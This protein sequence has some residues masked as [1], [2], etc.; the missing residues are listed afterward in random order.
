MRFIK[1]LLVA[2]LAT[3]TLGGQVATAEVPTL[4]LYLVRHGQSVDN[5]SGL[6][7]GWSSTPLTNL[8]QRQAG[9]LG[10]KISSF[11]ITAAYSSGSVRA[12]ATLDILLATLATPP[13]PKTD[14]RF[15]EWGVGSFDQKPSAQVKAVIA[16]RLKT[17]VADLWKF[18]DGQKMDA[19]A[20]ADPTHKA[21]N[22]KK[23]KSRIT[24]GLKAVVT[25]NPGGSVL[26]VS[27]GYVIKHLIKELTGSWAKADI[28]NATL[29]ELDLVGGKWVMVQQPTLNPL[30][31]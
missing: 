23:F 4:H 26:V 1:F 18:T 24:A 5:A 25:A 16:K 12:K 11:P 22:W 19:L 21:E 3:T 27:H 17:S 10:G 14:S 29:T 13:A 15:R 2:I 20:A 7:S 31:K 6:Q 30:L 28:A 9:A 8:G